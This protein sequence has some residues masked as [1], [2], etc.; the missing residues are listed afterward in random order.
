MFTNLIQ[1]LQN[2][3]PK[4][5]LQTIFVGATALTVGVTA[6]L[7]Y[8]P[9]LWLS[10]KNIDD[11][12]LKINQET[13]QGVSAELASLFK[14]ATASQTLLQRVSD[15]NVLSIDRKEVIESTFISFLE[16]NPQLNWAMLGYPNGDFLGAQRTG[17]KTLKLH[18]RQWNAQTNQSLHTTLSYE[19][20]GQSLDLIKQE[21]ENDAKPYYAPDRPWYKEAMKTP[22]QPGWTTYVRRTNNQPTVDSAI[23]VNKGGSSIGVLNFGFD[24]DQISQFLKKLQ[25]HP[26]STLIITNRKAQILASSDLQEVTPKQI[27]GQDE[28]NLNVLDRA[29]NPLIQGI[30]QEIKNRQGG[31][32]EVSGIQNFRH[33]DPQ[34]GEMYYATFI[35]LNHLD[36]SIGIVNPESLYLGE[37][38]R[39]ELILLGLL[40][41]FIVLTLTI[42]IRF[43]KRFLVHPILKLNHAAKQVAEQEFSSDE[44]QDLLDR[45]DE[46][47]ELTHTLTEM[48]AHIDGREQGLRDQVKTLK[49]QTE[50]AQQANDST[51]VPSPFSD[52]AAHPVLLLQ[53]AQALRQALK[54]DLS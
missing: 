17:A 47:G 31:N 23:T 35:P 13:A 44:L 18:R 43:T 48:A 7:V 1:T 27:P 37:I 6:A 10:N 19:M 32:A 20:R 22:G 4:R 54:A 29:Q 52:S 9:W 51:L 21:S 53:R 11:L 3:K 42:A 49:R 38:R 12:T 25:K 24:L 28:T 8:F 39:D 30:A 33:R 5:N 16:A 36:W 50:Q 46:I 41:G 45:S 15:R 26:Q 40:I 14:S 34:S 2:L